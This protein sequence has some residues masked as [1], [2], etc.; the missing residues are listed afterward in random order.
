MACFPLLLLRMDFI[1]SGTNSS[2]RAFSIE[3]CIYC[4]VLVFFATYLY[5]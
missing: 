1:G 3:V 4:S 2:V 5:F